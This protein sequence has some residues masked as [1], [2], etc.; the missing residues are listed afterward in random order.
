LTT[1]ESPSSPPQ[2]LVLTA[3]AIAAAVGGHLIAGG[4]GLPVSGFSIDTRTLV[5]GD[6]FFA[7]RGERF[8]GHAFVAEALRL[9]AC[10]AVLSDRALLASMAVEGASVLI[11]SK[12][13]VWALQA[14]AQYVRRMSQASVVAVTGSAGKSTTKEIAAEFLSTRY[15]VFRNQ[16][17]LNNHI[18]LP[19]SLLGLR[20]RPDIAV[21]EFGMNHAGEIS[22]LV[23]IAE[24]EVRVW[25]TLARPISGSSAPWRRLPMPRPRCWRRPVRTTC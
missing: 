10:G 25:T 23:G 19:L 24:P 5:P 7:I 11:G 22:T 15:Q 18:G 12:D 20:R 16:G 17:N 2:E 13:T 4:T 3:G 14:L 8:D 9:G 1:P 21:V 6:L